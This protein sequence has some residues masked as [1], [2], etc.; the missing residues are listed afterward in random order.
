MIGGEGLP[1]AAMS[2]TTCPMNDNRS[3]R[4]KKNKTYTYRHITYM[5]HIEVNMTISTILATC[6]LDLLITPIKLAP[7]KPISRTTHENRYHSVPTNRGLAEA[8]DTA[9]KHIST[10]ISIA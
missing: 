8:E 2:Y 9:G 6:V 10:I 7:R 3:N 1:G 5:S 4:V